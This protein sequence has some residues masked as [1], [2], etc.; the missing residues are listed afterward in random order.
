MNKY[1]LQ[2]KYYFIKHNVKLSNSKNPLEIVKSLMHQEYINIHGPEHHFLDGA[3]FLVAF[4]NAGG[5]LDI[6]FAL[7]TLSERSNKM[8]GAM[9]GYWG[10]CGAVTSIGAALS[11]I[12]ETTPLSCDS[13]YA[14]HMEFTSS[15][16]SKMSKIGGP[17]CCKRNAYLALSEGVLYAN[18]E[19]NVNMEL[20]E[21][22][23]EFK[24]L[25]KQCIKNRC[26]F[27]K[28]NLY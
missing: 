17:R 24:E 27:H 8:P 5:K 13:S 25:N 10:V 14:K 23:C 2:E 4:K 18:K 6:D 26:P 15:L 20:E 1:T 22:N 7:E 28:N 19:Y 3:A 21:N 12:D 9:C 16:L 11:I